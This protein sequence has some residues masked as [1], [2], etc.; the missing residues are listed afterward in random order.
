MAGVVR[1]FHE[2]ESFATVAAA[3]VGS[4]ESAAIRA[5]SD[6]GLIEF[7]LTAALALFGGGNFAFR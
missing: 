2:D 1:T 4:L 5:L 3:I 6:R 7:D